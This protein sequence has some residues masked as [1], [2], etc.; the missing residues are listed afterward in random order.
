MN[1]STAP[2][3]PSSKNLPR[4][5]DVD[6]LKS[7]ARQLQISPNRPNIRRI[8]RAFDILEKGSLNFVGIFEGKARLYKCESQTRPAPHPHLLISNGIVQCTCEDAR[9]FARRGIQT[10]CKH[11]IALRLIEAESHQ[12]AE[13][14]EEAA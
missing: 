4:V 7:V 10:E 3:V 6:T 13:T 5:Y 8:R 11:G 1:N 14:N 2:A 12:E 9:K